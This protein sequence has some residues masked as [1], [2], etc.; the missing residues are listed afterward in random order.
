[1]EGDGDRKRRWTRALGLLGVTF[2][3]SVVQPVVLVAV[4]LTLLAMSTRER[5]GTALLVM[6]VAGLLA[7]GGPSRFGLWY[8][9]R[10]WAV[11]VGGWFV[12][13]SLRWPGTRFL[14]R[15]LGAVA[16]TFTAV[17]LLFWLRPEGWAVADWTI[18]SRL[19]EGASAALQAFRML[20]DDG[21]GISSTLTAAV[22]ETAKLQGTVFPALL[23][24][25]SVA[26]LGVA[27]WLYRRLVHG[28]DRGLGP[29]ADF[30]FNDQL[31]W[32][33]IGGCLLLLLTEGGW[34]RTG[35]NAVVFMGGL[36]ALRGAAVVVFLAGGV[37]FLG[38]VL[39]GLGLIL[40]PPLI[41][42]GALVIGLGDTWLDIRAKAR[43][44]TG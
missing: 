35:A 3:L 24:L 20:Q 22:H 2:V 14:T 33:L 12:A 16:G 40:L 25:S 32:V 26:G 30:R 37:S 19:T 34:S 43:A 10:G 18:T 6:V 38:A 44:S 13:L 1:M 31:V 11:M 39:A 28:S 36:Y 23:G 9:E 21:S 4:P 8:L 7:V 41:L 27:W 29:L 17:T 15:G 5:T 42:A